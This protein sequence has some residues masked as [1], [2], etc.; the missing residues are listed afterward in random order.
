MNSDV[1]YICPKT[2]KILKTVKAVRDFNYSWKKD[3]KTMFEYRGS[4]AD[5]LYEDEDAEQVIDRALK[6]AGVR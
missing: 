1:K 3:M 5:S 6:D 2:G 4:T